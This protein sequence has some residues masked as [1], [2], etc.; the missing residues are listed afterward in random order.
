MNIKKSVFI[1]TSMDG[2]IARADGS[3]DWL[4]EAHKNSN[5]DFGYNHFIKE[6]DVIIMG[7][8]TF[9]HV[10]SFDNWAYGKIKIIVLSSC[11]INLPD[12][13]NHDVEITSEPK[14]DLLKK[15]EKLNYKHAY[16][17]GG[18]TIQSFLIEGLIDEITITAI[19]VLIGGGIS[20]FGNL[21]TDIKLKL[22]S[23]RTYDNG[24]VQSTYEIIK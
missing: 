2:F 18:K 20:L 9:E 24:F 8:K 10:L 3:I 23:S 22:L 15:L 21:S 11:K 16:I 6:V 7:R 1:A 5:E 4:L 19:P 17:D 14:I 12:N 13:F